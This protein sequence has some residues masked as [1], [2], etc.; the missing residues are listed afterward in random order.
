MSRPSVISYEDVKRVCLRLLGSKG[1]ATVDAIYEGLGRKGSKTTINNHR[2]QFFSELAEKGTN[3]LPASL[4]KELVPLVEEW[5]IQ[6]L[7]KAGEAFSEDR[8]RLEAKMKALADEATVKHEEALRYQNLLSQRDIKIEH[9]GQALVTMSERN[10]DLRDTVEKLERQLQQALAS[11][12]QMLNQFE[13]ERR[14]QAELFERERSEWRRDR[15]HLQ[16]ELESS[17]NRE[18]AEHDRNLKQV[19]YWI[20]Q[21]DQERTRVATIE[22][23]RKQDAKRF[24]DELLLNRK[25]EESMSVRLGKFEQ[26][27]EELSSDKERLQEQLT[28]ERLSA[29]SKERDLNVRISELSLELARAEERVVYLESADVEVADDGKEPEKS[30]PKKGK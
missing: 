2:R 8:E 25:R 28:S 20:L 16:T 12:E 7:D 14:E 19:D 3:I 9:Q 30:A 15:D 1:S 11:H 23:E 18:E 22:G 24:Q 27:I 21:V 29:V 17:L 5:W 26:R 6:A 10:V 4:P 13:Q